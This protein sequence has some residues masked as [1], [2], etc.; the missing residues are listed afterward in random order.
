MPAPGCFAIG[1][2]RIQAAPRYGSGRS[3]T[4]AHRCR[5]VGVGVNI[6]NLDDELAIW[7]ASGEA[8]RN[9]VRPGGATT[10]GGAACGVQSIGTRRGAPHW[11]AW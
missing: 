6:V 11:N 9:L 1:L 10:M 4:R 2:H 7:V 3:V 5:D 8:F